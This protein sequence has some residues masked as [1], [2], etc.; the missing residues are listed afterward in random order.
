MTWLAGSFYLGAGAVGA[1]NLAWLAFRRRARSS[2]IRLS[3]LSWVVML[4]HCPISLLAG[5]VMVIV[6]PVL[7][8]RAFRSG[9]QLQ[10]AADSLLTQD[11]DDPPIYVL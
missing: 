1:L 8:V 7:S 10:R 3:A 2:A 11:P 9:R 6:R 4:V 5:S